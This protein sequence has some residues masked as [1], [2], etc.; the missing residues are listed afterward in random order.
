MS[1]L[2]S[3]AVTL[4]WQQGHSGILG[5]LSSCSTPALF[6]PPLTHTLLI[7]LFISILFLHP[8]DTGRPPWD[9][10]SP[11]YSSFSTV[12]YS[13]NNHKKRGVQMALYADYTLQ[14]I[15]ERVKDMELKIRRLEENARNN[16]ILSV[17]HA[18]FTNLAGR[19]Q[20]HST[21]PNRRR[22]LGRTPH[23]SE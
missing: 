3:V 20:Q 17:W 13:I 1:H 7:I 16:T 4:D 21:A 11:L 6:P 2:T 8:K 9:A 12:D 22:L 18:I 10:F 5:L 19:C 23:S 14:N 15:L